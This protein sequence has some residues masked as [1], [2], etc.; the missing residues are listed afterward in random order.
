MSDAAG[1]GVGVMDH[2]VIGHRAA[3]EASVRSYSHFASLSSADEQSGDAHHHGDEEQAGA[4]AFNHTA[5][6]LCR[7]KEHPVIRG[8]L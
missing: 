3:E 5:Q 4:D 1:A 2:S 6:R 8:P 7:P